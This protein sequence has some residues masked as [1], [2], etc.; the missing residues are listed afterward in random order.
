MIREAMQ[1]SVI[2]LFAWLLA[3]QP[4]FTY[5]MGRCDCCPEGPSTPVEVETGTPSGDGCCPA[6]EAPDESVPHDPSDR[7]GCDTCP[8][9]CC[10]GVS[11]VGIAYRSNEGI[12]ACDAL[13]WGEAVIESDA[14][15]PSSRLKRPPRASALV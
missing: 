15:A 14:R 12:P 5:G 10:T 2:I 11:V 1:A 13:S 4:V 6:P 3:F 7:D 9:P 8:Q